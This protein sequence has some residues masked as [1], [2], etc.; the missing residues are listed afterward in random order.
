MTQPALSRSIRQLEQEI[1]SALVVR[2]TRNVRLT[3]LGQRLVDQA[4]PLLEQLDDVV[5]DALGAARERRGQ[6][7]VGFKAGAAGR[8][9]TPTVMAFEAENPEV[10]VELHRLDWVDQIEGLLDDRVDVA[11]VWLPLPVK[12][13]EIAQ[14]MSEPRYVGVARDHRFATREHLTIDE[15]RD[16]PVVTA[17][18][19]PA[20][21][22][23]WW[24]A[25]PRPDGS[26]PPTGATADSV[27]EMLEIVARGRGTCFVARSFEAFYGRPDVVFIPVLDLEP[28]P[29]ALAWRAGEQRAIVSAF[30][31]AAAR[32]GAALAAETALLAPVV[33][34][35]AR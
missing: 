4:S 7:R 22:A 25:I 27:E 35:S 2:T 16:E 9:L 6:L 3:E 23:R 21:I 1:G 26:T 10:E 11:F 14:L 8:L 12:G 31:D 30:R 32:A 13:I 20:E 17:R 24:S 15:L 18:S 29:I 34:E 33:A 19:V 28:A 5:S